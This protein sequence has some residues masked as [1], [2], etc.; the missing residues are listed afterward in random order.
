MIKATKRSSQNR[1]GDK[2]D[3]KPIRGL[4]GSNFILFAF[5]SGL[6]KNAI[7]RYSEIRSSGQVFS[8]LNNNLKID[9]RMLKSLQKK[10]QKLKIVKYDIL[11]KKIW[12]I[13]VFDK[14]HENL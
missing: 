8:Q 3:E 12:N 4:F 11:Q 13:E 1:N 2:F 7:E 9:K 14:I 6:I 10:V 5:R